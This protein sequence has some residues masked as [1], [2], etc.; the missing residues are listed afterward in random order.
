MNSNKEK[1]FTWRLNTFK[2][3]LTQ[4]IFS[5]TKNFKK[6][7]V[8]FLLDQYCSPLF[9]SLSL[10]LYLSIS[11]SLFYYNYEGHFL[12]FPHPA[13]HIPLLHLPFIYLSLSQIYFPLQ[14]V[15]PLLFMVTSKPS[16]SPS[17]SPSLS[18]TLSLSLSFY[19]FLS[20]TLSF[21]LYFFT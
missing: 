4:H 2:Q 3:I 20:Q 13:T 19:L 16:L 12:V 5:S 11:L 1:I 10:L 8:T 6:C 9:L 15:F 17:P 21:F 7:K 18:L 14:Q